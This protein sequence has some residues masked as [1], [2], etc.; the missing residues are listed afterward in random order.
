MSRF[1]VEYNPSIS[2][3]AKKIIEENVVAS[4]ESRDACSYQYEI[5]QIISAVA[6]ILASDDYE[7]LRA[8]RDEEVEYIEIDLNF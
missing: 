5:D 6:N 8:L 4:M 2:Q 7:K 1:T 3:D